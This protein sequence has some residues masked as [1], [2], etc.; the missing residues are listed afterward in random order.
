MSSTNSS[1]LVAVWI[2]A[3]SESHANRR[4]KKIIIFSLHFLLSIKFNYLTY[5]DAF[6]SRQSR[7]LVNV[8]KRIACLWSKIANKL[9]SLSFT[10]AYLIVMPID[11]RW[12]IVMWMNRRATV[13]QFRCYSMIW[14]F[15]SDKSVARFFWFKR[16]II[17]DS[18]TRDTKKNVQTLHNLSADNIQC[19]STNVI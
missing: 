15:V 6:Y 3:R 9:N 4:T 19:S 7:K 1:L 18:Q 11:D 13:C 10:C 2:N 14:A 16:K 17:R 12:P 8:S 5:L